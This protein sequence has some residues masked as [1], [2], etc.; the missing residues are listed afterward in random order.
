M[1]ENRFRL[2]YSEDRGKADLIKLLFAYSNQVYEDFK[3]KP[4][5]WNYY[6]S[7]TPFEQLPVL[8]VDEKIQIAQATTIARFLAKKFNL[9]GSDD[10]ESTMCDMIVEQIRECGDFAAQIIQ[11]IDSNKKRLLSQRYLNEI[12]PKTLSGFEKMLNL[13]GT[14]R[15]VGNQLTWADLA[16]ANSLAWLDEFSLQLL[17]NYPLVKKHN[18]SIMSIPSVNGWFKSQKPLSVFKKA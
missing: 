1:S 9:Q 2:M 12:L 16:L 4:A 15:I 18:E 13:N 17:Q 10:I 8:I 5:E 14:N 11:E 7:Y 3:I 6:K